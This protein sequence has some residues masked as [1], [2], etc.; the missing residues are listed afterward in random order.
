M[1][2]GNSHHDVPSHE[3]LDGDE[4]TAGANTTVTWDTLRLLRATTAWG[5]KARLRGRH[6]GPS[7]RPRSRATPVN[8]DNVFESH[9]YMDPSAQRSP[10]IT[11]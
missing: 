11:N 3:C 1:L 6:R 7:R 8:Q 2:E 5:L 4:Y 9:E 10:F